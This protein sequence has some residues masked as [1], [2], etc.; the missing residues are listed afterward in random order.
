ML[1]TLYR[2][3]HN[4]LFQTTSFAM[5]T[6][7]TVHFYGPNGQ[8]A[9]GALLERL[10]DFERKISLYDPSSEI[11][12]LNA[13]A[14]DGEAVALSEDTYGLLE[15]AR[16]YSLD[17]G[18]VFDI[19]VAPLSLLW[20]VTGENPHVPQEEEILSRRELVDAR[21]RLLDPEHRTAR[22]ARQGQSVDLGGIAK[23]EATRFVFDVMDEYGI[24]NGYVSLGGNMAVRGKY[25]DTGEDFPFGVRDPRG[26]GNEYLGI[27]TLDG[28]TMATTGDYERFFME[29]GVRYHH[30]L[31]PRTGYP[32]NGG[33]IS[34][35]VISQDGAR[36][37][38]LSTSLFVAG[39]EEALKH[40]EDP[41]I[42]L[43]LVD[44]DQNVYLSPSLQ[45][46]FQENPDKSQYHFYYGAD[47]AG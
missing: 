32:A 43:I 35:T 42:S 6:V 9:S 16:Q 26:A 20:D 2:N 18:G 39:K 30:V 34:V 44:E 31:D 22:L 10:R 19:T 33:L 15:K 45:G 1:F 27:I 5:D 36:A 12:Q 21:D 13:K 7:I 24:E 14:G 25:P 38:A 17:S 47:A 41:G 37:D 11:A 40:L 8:E 3:A 23:G 28:L 4:R 29:D 46:R